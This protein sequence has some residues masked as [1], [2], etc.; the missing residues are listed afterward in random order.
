MFSIQEQW[1][2]I[3]FSVYL[4]FS[5]LVYL[6]NFISKHFLYKYFEL[7]LICSGAKLDIILHILYKYIYNFE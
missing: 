3:V 7:I 5:K 1:S 6:N 2:Y 4:Q